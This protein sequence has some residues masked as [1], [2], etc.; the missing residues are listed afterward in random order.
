MKGKDLF[1]S[2]TTIGVI[3]MIL[4]VIAEKLWGLDIG[5]QGEMTTSLV[6]FIAHG[7]EFAAAGI[8][9]RGRIKAVQPITSILGKPVTPPSQ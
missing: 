1:T 8:T 4:A 2:K 6:G 7:F 9:L 3:V 5:D